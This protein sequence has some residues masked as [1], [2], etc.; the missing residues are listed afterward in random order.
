MTYIPHGEV[1]DL[2][3]VDVYRGYTAATGAGAEP[4]LL[5]FPV[6]NKVRFIRVLW[7]WYTTQGGYLNQVSWHSH[8]ESLIDAGNWGALQYHYI[9]HRDITHNYKGHNL[10][11]YAAVGYGEPLYNVQV[12][13][14]PQA[15]IYNLS[16]DTTYGVRLGGYAPVYTSSAD[17]TARITFRMLLNSTAHCN[18]LVLVYRVV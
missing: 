9:H 2:S 1:T 13:S 17:F 16:Y 10:T 8:G 15:A 11:R 6:N 18:A 4:W 5:T 7:Q 14:T 12:R 3:R